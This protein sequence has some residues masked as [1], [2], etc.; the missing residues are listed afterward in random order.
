MYVPYR[1]QIHIENNFWLFVKSNPGMC[2]STACTFYQ[3]V[4]T[5][6]KKKNC[7]YFLI[8]IFDT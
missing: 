3:L 1:E 6:L 2:C 5:N 8:C 7:N 4:E